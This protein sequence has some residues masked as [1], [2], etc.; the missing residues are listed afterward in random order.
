MIDD[1]GTGQV[2]VQVQAKVTL[3]VSSVRPALLPMSAVGEQARPGDHKH[4]GLMLHTSKAAS[5]GELVEQVS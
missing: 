2:Q 5:A 4:Q 1:V 3:W